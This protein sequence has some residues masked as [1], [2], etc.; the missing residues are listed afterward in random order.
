MQTLVFPH[1]VE[2]ADPVAAE[3][4]FESDKAP[5]VAESNTGT[6]TKS[7]DTEAVVDI[8]EDVRKFGSCYRLA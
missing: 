3:A 4:T 6:D 5:V 7:Q 1:T 8:V 2:V